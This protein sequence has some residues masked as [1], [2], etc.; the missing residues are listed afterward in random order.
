MADG[1]DGAIVLWRSKPG[2]YRLLREQDWAFGAFAAVVL[3]NAVGSQVAPAA[4]GPAQAMFFTFCSLL[5]TYMLVR[6]LLRW[7]AL[8]RTR[9]ELTD[10]G[11]RVKTGRRV[12]EYA[13]I[14][15][16]EPVLRVGPAGVGS[17][18]FGAFPGALEM[19]AALGMPFRGPLAPKRPM[20]V[21]FWD[22]PEA[23]RVYASVL[24]AIAEGQRKRWLTG[25]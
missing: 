25:A 20:P 2:R 1:M 22:V 4:R 17:I 12:A 8:R 19:S 9:Y 21:V 18:C 6:L 10:R 3:F 14:A 13:W 16:P 5:L 15:L 7:F 11:V 23:R 24:A